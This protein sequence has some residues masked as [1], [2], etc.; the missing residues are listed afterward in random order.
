MV[1]QIAKLHIFAADL[2]NSFNG[3]ISGSGDFQFGENNL[4]RLEL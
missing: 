4:Y 1:L 3:L 2:F